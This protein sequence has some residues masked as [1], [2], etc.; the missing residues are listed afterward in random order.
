MATKHNLVSTLD[1]VIHE[2]WGEEDVDKAKD[3]VLGHINASKVK[4]ED[5][6]RIRLAMGEIK[7]KRKLDFY[8]ANALL[9]FEGHGLNK[10]KK[11]GDIR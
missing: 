1:K 11:G 4:D 8:L 5:K 3:L 6:K 9:K 2:A 7:T 10:F